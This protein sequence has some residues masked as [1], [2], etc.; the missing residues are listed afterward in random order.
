MKLAF[1]I[2]ITSI[3]DDISGLFI[4]IA[5]ITLIASIFLLVLFFYFEI[6]EDKEIVKGIK[7]GMKIFI[8]VCVVVVFIAALMPSKQ[9][10]YLMAG[11]YIGELVIKSEFT[12]KRLEKVIEIIDLNLDKQIKELQ[13]VNK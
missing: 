11:A 6:E 2:Y 10:A 5:V 7:T 4:N 1:L 9:T 8:P 12:N 13:K 3:L